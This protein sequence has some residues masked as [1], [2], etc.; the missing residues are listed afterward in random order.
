MN[1]DLSLGVAIIARSTLILVVIVP[2]LL[3]LSTRKPVVSSTIICS[4]L[5]ALLVLPGMVTF[6]P[7][8][9]VVISMNSSETNSHSS[10]QDRR[11]VERQMQLHDE[12]FPSN[13]SN[14]VRTNESVEN[15]RIEF[16]TEL[17]SSV[18]SDE[19]HA[20][21]PNQT[22]FRSQ[23]LVESQKPERSFLSWRN[24]LV[25]VYFFGVGL[26]FA[27]FLLGIL[28]VIRLTR[29]SVMAKTSWE[30]VHQSCCR[31]LAIRRRVS[32]RASD[33]ITIPLTVGS[34]RPIILIPSFL[35]DSTKSDIESILL[36]ELAHVKRQ[37]SLWLCIQ[38]IVE[39]VYW[40][41]PLVWILGLLARDSRERACDDL[42]VNLTQNREDYRNALIS[43]AARALIQR[44]SIGVAMAHSSKLKSRLFY[45]DRTSGNSSCI[46]GKLTCTLI[47]AIIFGILV[48]GSSIDVV[49]AE[50][51]TDT[52][53]Q[54]NI[55]NESTSQPFNAQNID[56]I[57]ASLAT[58]E[59]HGEM[60]KSVVAILG[61][62]KLQHWSF[63]KKVR[64]TPNGRFL[65]SASGDGTVRVWNPNTGE[66]LNRFAP[67][68][69]WQNGPRHVLSLAVHP[70]G[71][72]VAAGFY[73]GFRIWDLDANREILDQRDKVSVLGIDFHPSK[74]I[75]AT[76]SSSG[77]KLWDLKSGKVLFDLGT[78][79]EEIGST[80]LRR[81]GRA[82]L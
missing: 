59:N 56:S 76:S 31:R 61:S 15:S 63:V 42:C 38:R 45:I 17:E 26:F 70:N 67:P 20:A 81:I 80:G 71:K 58:S 75:L 54:S 9:P 39:A 72:F 68:E 12:V 24:A 66:Q 65:V 33:Q 23:R 79:Q 64:F 16:N 62:G 35:Q 25:F 53:N 4:V 13:V 21:T 82:L 34:W 77:G 5:V 36:H 74:S 52:T 22:E 50:D 19:S 2:L 37:D 57:D 6:G 40:F 43:V 44:P 27:R 78:K 30:A 51:E 8:V 48:S 49:S 14:L 7:R 47:F 1:L 69:P 73:Y 60:P 32:L 10:D 3:W 46:S 41:H 28:G 11:L 18:L 29:N 55:E